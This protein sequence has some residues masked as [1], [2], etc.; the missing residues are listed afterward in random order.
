MHTSTRVLMV[1]SETVPFAKSGGLADVVTSLSAALFERGVDVRILMPYY[2][3]IHDERIEDLRV[4]FTVPLGIGEEIGRLYRTQLPQKAVPVY[5]LSNAHLFGRE[6]IYG[7]SDNVAYPDNLRRFAFFNRAVFS[8]CRA[9]DWI[10]Q[11][12]HLHDWPTGLVPSYLKGPQ[13]GAE[14][15]ETASVFTIHNIGYQ[16]VF[17]RQDLYYT[18]LTWDAIRDARNPAD[19][20]INLLRLGLREAHMLTTVSPSYALEIQTPKYGAGLDHLLVE[21]SSELAGILNGMDYDEWNPASDPLIP[22]HFATEGLSGKA[23][24]KAVLQSRCGFSVDPEVPLI[25]IV[26]RLVDQKGFV[27]LADPSNGSI[28]RICGDMKVQLVV[29]G[30][31]EKWCEEQLKVLDRE[32]PNFRAVIGFDNTMAHLIEAGADFF[33]MPSRYEPCGLNQMYSLRYGTLPIARRTGGLADTIEQF[34]QETGGGTGFLFDD[35]TPKSVYDVTGWAIWAWYNRRE[36][37]HRMV[38]RAMQKRFSWDDSAS[39]YLEVYASARMRRMKASEA[40]SR[41]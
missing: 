14:F 17:A 10:P 20:T 29:L 23:R 19:E 22:H 11:I 25:G 27:E 6:G 31:G 3:F 4:E 7:G 34:D 28:R 18:E 26:S 32:L 37:I 16:G 33:L 15:G 40:S 12:I 39:Q 1:T 41:S 8:V 35:L 9:I 21:R 36:H 2:S 30:T 24:D 38:L 5:L 13:C